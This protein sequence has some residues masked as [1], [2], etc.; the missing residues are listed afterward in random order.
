MKVPVE[1]RE[2]LRT[3]ELWNGQEITPIV[4]DVFREAGA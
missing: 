1:L 4:M 2:A 3:L